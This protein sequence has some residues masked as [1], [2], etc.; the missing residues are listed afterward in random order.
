MSNPIQ[1][2]A[3]DF[4]QSAQE[5]LR[6]SEQVIAELGLYAVE[7]AKH[8][9]AIVG[10]PGYVDA[11]LVERDNVATKA[12][13]LTTKRADELDQRLLGLIHGTLLIG[14]RLLLV[15]GTVAP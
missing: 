2:F 12:A 1:D 3:K 10:Q 8:L 14:A 13:T 9:T 7:R 5:Y 15:A 6:G 11:V 4:E